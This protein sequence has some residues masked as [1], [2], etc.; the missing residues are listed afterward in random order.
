MSIAW[1]L[2][3]MCCSITQNLDNCTTV[4]P[5]NKGQFRSRALVLF[6]EVVLWW[7]NHSNCYNLFYKDNMFMC[8]VCCVWTLILVREAKE[9]VK[10]QDIYYV[11]YKNNYD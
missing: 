2:V 6:S 10:M 1:V 7:E 3:H 4:E 9:L 11:Q 5:P 8:V